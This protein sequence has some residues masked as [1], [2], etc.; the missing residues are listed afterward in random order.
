M[1]VFRVVI[2]T[3]HYPSTDTI[4]TDHF[5]IYKSLE[6]QPKPKEAA[7]VVVGNSLDVTVFRSG[8]LNG[9]LIQLVPLF[10]R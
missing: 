6:P 1:R 7:S 9:A 3:S 5:R 8:L 2:L 10:R 4:A